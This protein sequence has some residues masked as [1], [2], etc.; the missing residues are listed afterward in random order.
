MF[1]SISVSASISHKKRGSKINITMVIQLDYAT[2]LL[3]SLVVNEY[4]RHVNVKDKGE[5]L[6]SVVTCCSRS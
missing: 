2:V 5:Y 1:S 4:A 6:D 3:S